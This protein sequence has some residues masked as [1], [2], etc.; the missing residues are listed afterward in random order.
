M[1]G[2]TRI[3]EGGT[4]QGA[5]HLHDA[6]AATR[7]LMVADNSARSTGLMTWP[8]KPLDNIF[9]LSSTRPYRQRQ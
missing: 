7:L 3:E 8:S 1:E 6:R 2:I 9:T 5:S 4:P